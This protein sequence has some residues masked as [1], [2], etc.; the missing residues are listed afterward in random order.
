MWGT[1][2][3][4]ERRVSRQHAFLVTGRHGTEPGVQGAKLVPGPT[5]LPCLWVAWMAPG[6]KAALCS[7]RSAQVPGY[8]T[9]DFH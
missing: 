9:E 8:S 5:P 1:L 6:D 7:Q 2:G 3:P 4:H